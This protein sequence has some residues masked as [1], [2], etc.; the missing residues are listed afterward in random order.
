MLRPSLHKLMQSLFLIAQMI[1]IF[2]LLY[3]MFHITILFYIVLM[4]VETRRHYVKEWDG[5]DRANV[6]TYYK[7]SQKVLFLAFCNLL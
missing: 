2:L 3:L 1:H 6:I 5:G 4:I 7:E